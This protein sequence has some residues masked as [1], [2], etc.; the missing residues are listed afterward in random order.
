MQVGCDAYFIG[1]CPKCGSPTDKT[2]FE[3]GY[4]LEICPACGWNKKESNENH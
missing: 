2:D 1:K 4:E 3:L